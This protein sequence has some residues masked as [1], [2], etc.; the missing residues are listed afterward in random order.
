[1]EDNKT[2][3]SPELRDWKY[4]SYQSG[5]QLPPKKI[6]CFQRS[7]S[8]RVH[9]THFQVAE[10]HHRDLSIPLPVSVARQGPGLGKS[11]QALA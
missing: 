3:S 5:V 1:M 8:Q 4:G 2:H 6:Q 11:S 9:C 7:R 10:T